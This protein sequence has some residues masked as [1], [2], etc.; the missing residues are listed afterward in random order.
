[1]LYEAKSLSNLP[2]LSLGLGNT[3][4]ISSAI[5]IDPE[6]GKLLGI[7]LRSKY[8]WQTSKV[9]AFSDIYKINSEII[10][11]KDDQSLTNLESIV[12]IK[13][14]VDQKIYIL[15]SQV[16]TESGQKLGK[17]ENFVINA[18]LGILAK[19]YVEGFLNKDYFKG[20]RVIPAN[21]IISIERKKIVVT[22]D[23]LDE[24]IESTEMVGQAALS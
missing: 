16:M 3:L 21:K 17:T 19:I 9:I 12:R 8:F 18:D 5:I 4:G 13:K 7:L 11:V 14:V 2:V 1:M 10:L 6:T 15:G 20:T 22:D 23:A 24:R